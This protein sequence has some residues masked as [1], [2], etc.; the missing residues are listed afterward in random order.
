M[1]KGNCKKNQN[2]MKKKIRKRNRSGVGAYENRTRLKQYGGGITSTGNR[3]TKR[4]TKR[5]RERECVKAKEGG[6]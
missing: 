6:M 4:E 2:Q 1:V 5:E 3:K